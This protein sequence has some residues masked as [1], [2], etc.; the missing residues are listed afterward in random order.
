MSTS[1]ST[2]ILITDLLLLLA[3]EQ[4]SESGHGRPGCSPHSWCGRPL[5]TGQTEER[6]GNLKQYSDKLF[7]LGKEVYHTL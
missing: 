7:M 6:D 3:A 4:A 5:G 1:A 2:Q